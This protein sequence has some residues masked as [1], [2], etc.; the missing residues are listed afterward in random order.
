MKKSAIA[1]YNF[2]KE[3]LDANPES[4][5][6]FVDRFRAYENDAVARYFVNKE[7]FERAGGYVT[8]QFPILSDFKAS[9]GTASGHYFHQDLVVANYVYKSNPIRHVDVGSRVDGFV[10]HVASFR[11]ID[12]IDI[13]PVGDCGHGNIRFYQ[14]D[15]L[16]ID[17]DSD[18]V[19]DSI[20]CLHAIEH[21]GLGRYGDQI[22]PHGH[23]KGFAAILSIL[24]VLGTL[25]ISFPI[26]RSNEI[27]FNAHR[28]FHP[29]DILSWPGA[30]RLKLLNFDFVDDAGR[31]HRNIDLT[32]QIPSCNHGCG[33]YTFSKAI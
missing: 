24:E 8:H 31:L 10:A 22:D 21:F 1:L 27:H 18:F 26:G 3:R 9:G 32:R 15:I 19:S 7:S 2:V 16:S 13:R 6:E 30:D 29:L 4:Y 12:C 33:I 28:V 25:Y 17:G 23:K 14:R 11:E 20:S 5:F